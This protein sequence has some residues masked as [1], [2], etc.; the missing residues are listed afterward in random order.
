MPATVLAVCVAVAVLV[1][2][3]E[4]GPR[5][6]VGGVVV[7]DVVVLADEVVAADH[8]LGREGVRSR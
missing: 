3:V 2:R 4:V 6:V 5:H 8:L 1:E 7:E